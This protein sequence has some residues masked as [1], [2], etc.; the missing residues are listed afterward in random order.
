LP[1]ADATLPLR[2]PGHH[3]SGPG[4]ASRDS[5]AAAASPVR[6]CAVVPCYNRPVDLLHL[7]HDLAALDLSVPRPVLLSILV[8]DN[9][10]DPPLRDLPLPE[11]LKVEVLRLEHNLGGSGGF[12]AGM[13]AALA[14]TME[15]A[16]ADMIWLLDS[17]A[18]VEPGTLA[19]LIRALDGD[20]SLAAAGS[21]L[22]DPATG[23]VHELGG[24][25]N[26]W[27]GR[28]QPAAGGAWSGAAA[29]PVV[30]YVPAC[31]ALVR[32]EAIRRTGL[33]PD[34]FLNG[35]DVEW[36]IRMGQVAGSVA[37]VPESRAWHPTY[38]RFQTWA[39]YYTARNGFGPIDA[40]GL[41]A[42][43]RFVRAMREVGR[44]L[45][46]ALLGRDDLAELHLAGLRDAA[47]GRRIGPAPVGTIRIE[48]PRP[49]TELETA[50]QEL[51]LRGSEPAPA[52]PPVGLSLLGMLAGL[53]RVALGRP[54]PVAVVPANGGPEH[55]GRGRRLVLVWPDGFVIRAANRASLLKSALR[56]VWRG[57]LLSLRLAAGAGRG[58]APLAR[59]PAIPA[60]AAAPGLT[61]SIII[62][63]YNR[64]EALERTLAQLD[65]QPAV[66]GDDERSAARI[67]VVDNASTDGTQARV[68]ECFPQVQL[69]ELEQNQGAGAFN[70]GAA[71]SHDDLLLILDDDACPDAAALSSAID[72]LARRPDLA[73]VALHPMHP[74]TRQ[75]EWPWAARRQGPLEN[76]PAMG[77]GNLVRRS[78]WASVGGYEGAFFLYRNDVDLALK[79]LNAGHGVY[80]DP[81][82]VVWHDS[83]AAARKSLRWFELAMR[84]WVWLCRR[85]GGARPGA[86]RPGGLQGTARFL[87]ALGLGWVWAHRLAG[88]G[89]RAHGRILCG[90]WRGM[91]HAPPPLPGACRLGGSMWRL[92]R[93]R[94]GRAD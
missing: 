68:R 57:V 61:L 2:L 77:C 81:S 22:L 1:P 73:A 71:T 84:N 28:F 79:L 47:A 65:Q 87:L 60:G 18:R 32:A 20:S 83:P 94:L 49:L 48:P 90:V 78:A 17:D 51:G 44:A 38:D 56:I 33:M 70:I 29:A 69:I 58:S 37:A 16:P 54:A 27:T 24:R 86:G 53:A 75:S 88:F 14:R 89:P 63:S 82:W 42:L 40:M 80:F 25:M 30:D 19:A 74:Q 91:R 67:I 55:W 4:P 36:F 8:V 92:I 62:L 35:D 93:L 76:F 12:N 21:A 6:I 26:R 15:G 64:W 34:V 50:L 43:V 72:L 46:Q 31:S 7:Q 9:A 45:M 3:P 13:A 41:G 85:H 5:A 52:A 39:R 11:G 10:S 23:H 59:P 66:R